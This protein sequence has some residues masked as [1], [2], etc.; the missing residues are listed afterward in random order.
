MIA[1]L[2]EPK[3]IGRVAAGLVLPQGSGAGHVWADLLPCG[4][5]TVVIE[6][7][8]LGH[9]GEYCFAYSILSI[10]PNDTGQT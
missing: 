8:D 3:Q 2:S 6:T 5:Q 4:K 7:R 1:K 9:A 10:T